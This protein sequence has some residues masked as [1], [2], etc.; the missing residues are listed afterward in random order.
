M[1]IH[2]I[3]DNKAKLFFK[4]WLYLL[5]CL[6]P[7]KW[8]PTILLQ[9]LTVPEPCQQIVAPNHQRATAQSTNQQEPKDI[10]PRQPRR[11]S[12]EVSAPAIIPLMAPAIILVNILFS[13][14]IYKIRL[15]PSLIRWLLDSPLT[16][17][18]DRDEFHLH[19]CHQCSFCLN[20]SW[21]QRGHQN[22]WD[23]LLQLFL[24][25]S[26]VPPSNWEGIGLSDCQSGLR[27]FHQ[28]ECWRKLHL[29]ERLGSFIWYKGNFTQTACTSIV[30]DQFLHDFCRLFQQSHL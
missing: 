10:F 17:A 20:Q 22:G 3:I 18:E 13:S 19:E 25:H 29:I 6:E 2:A 9:R 15:V 27:H 4:A 1:A 30:K 8:P 11:S 7:E 28:R 23:P 14:N 12:D 16:V 21:S 5:T 26:S 24:A